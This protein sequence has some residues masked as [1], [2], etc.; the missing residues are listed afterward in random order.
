[1]PV[2]DATKT[3]VPAAITTPPSVQAGIG[4]LEFTDG[5]PIGETAATLRDHLD[6]LHG[7][8]TFMNTIQGVSVTPS[9]RRS[10]RLGSRTATC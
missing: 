5:Y 3:P 4:T 8:E 2:T 1:M 10:W 6:Y 7:V 9:G